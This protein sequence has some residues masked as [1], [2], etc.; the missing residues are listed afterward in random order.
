MYYNYVLIFFSELL[1][2][3]K[4]KS[5]SLHF[6]VQLVCVKSALRPLRLFN[7]KPTLILCILTFKI[8]KFT[9]NGGIA[10]KP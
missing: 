6:T 1:K 10:Q 2:N 4:I 5:F 9:L 8:S 3:L 7:P